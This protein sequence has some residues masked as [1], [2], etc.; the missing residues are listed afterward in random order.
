MKEGSSR[1]DWETETDT[2]KEISAERDE[3]SE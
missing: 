1:R 3:V 2:D